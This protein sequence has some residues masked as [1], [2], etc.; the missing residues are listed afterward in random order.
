MARNHA[1][2]KRRKERMVINYQK[3]NDNT[4]FDG[5]Y[6]PSEIAIFN[7]IQGVSWFSKMDCKNG[8]W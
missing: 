5:Y 4:I 8:Y 6:I 3:L 2:E 1:E 7:K